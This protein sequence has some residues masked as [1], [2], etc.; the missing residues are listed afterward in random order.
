MRKPLLKISFI[1]TMILAFIRTEA[2]VS[3]VL[4]TSPAKQFFIDDLWKTTLINTSVKPVNTY[5]QFIIR[6]GSVNNVLT[7]TTQLITLM[8]GVNH[9]N[10]SDGTNGKW[11]YGSNEASTV[12]Q[13][14]GKL[15]YGHYTYGVYVYSASTN[16]LLGSSSEEIDVQPMLPPELASPRNEEV[17]NVKYPLLSW[18]PPRPII[19]LS[20]IYSLRL[21]A[22]QTDQSPAEGMLQ[23]PALVNLDNLPSTYTSYPVSSQSLQV[24]I[25]YAWQVGASYEGFS[26]GQTEIWTFTV[27]PPDPP[28]ADDIIYPVAAKTSDGHFYVTKGII[29]FAYDNKA[30]DKKL[31]YV[32]KRMD[33]HENLKS[34]P[35]IE[36]KAGMNKLEVDVSHNTGLKEK[37]YY[38]LEI[39]DK[40]GQVYKV[41]FYYITE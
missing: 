34:L 7:L 21:V 11:V 26:L 36:V 9:L 8:P 20:I 6:N 10:Q 23:N 29:R 18:I 15:P 16:R 25:T 1:V 30:N 2:Q 4:F 41:M 17:I 32:I 35:E 14:T 33:K 24:G 39:T 38:D 40:K 27:K 31:N 13:S 22:L 28:P 12:F 5:A 3:V 19:G 37:Q